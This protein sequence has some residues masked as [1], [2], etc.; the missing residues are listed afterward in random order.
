M[1][2]KEEAFALWNK[3]CREKWSASDRAYL[4]GYYRAMAGYAPSKSWK[5]ES[6]LEAHIMGH[7]DASGDWDLKIPQIPV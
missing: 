6:S 2:N 3:A 5:M 1:L 7:T 4:A